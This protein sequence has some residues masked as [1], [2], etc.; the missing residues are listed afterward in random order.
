[1]ESLMKP[2]RGELVFVIVVVL[3]NVVVIGGCL[4]VLLLY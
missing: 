4:A 2:N 3:I 1:M